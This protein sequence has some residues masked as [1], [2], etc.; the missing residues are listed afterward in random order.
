MIDRRASLSRRTGGSRRAGALALICSGA[1]SALLAPILAKAQSRSDDGPPQSISDSGL[2]PGAPG[3]L[4]TDLRRDPF[5]IDSF[6]SDPARTPYDSS[7]RGSEDAVDREDD[8][9]PAD[10]ADDA[11]IEADSAPE[12]DAEPVFDLFEGPDGRPAKPVNLA[13][14]PAAPPAA[15]GGAEELSATAMPR[16][17]GEGSGDRDADSFGERGGGERGRGERGR[18]ERGRGQGPDGQER[19]GQGENRDPLALA[20]NGGLPQRDLAIPSAAARVPIVET[21][22][23]RQNLALTALRGA[24]PIAEDDPFAPIGI[25]IGSAVMYSTV[26]QNVGVSSNLSTSADGESGVFSQTILS[27]RLLTDWSRHQFELNGLAAYRRNFAG[28]LESDPRVSLDGRFRLDI[29]RLTTATFRGAVDYGQ[30]DPIDLDDGASLSDR[31]QILTY[32]AG[33]GIERRFGRVIAALDASLVREDR[34][35][36]EET[37]N[38]V[39][40]DDSFTTYAASLRGGYEVSPALSP[41]VEGS[42]GLRRFD[43]ETDLSGRERNSTIPSLRT[44]VEFDL[45]EKFLGEVAVGYAFDIPDAQELETVGSPTIDARIAWSPHRGTDVVL[46]A[47]TVFDPD[48]DGSGTSTLYESALAL[49]HRLTHRTDVTGTVSLAY[50]DAEIE[51]EVE[52]SYAAEAGFT[53]WLNRGLA[54]TGLARHEALKTKISGSDYTAETVKVGIKLQR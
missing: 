48:P 5:S 21:V 24:I 36:P 45:G 6:S 22:T 37:A 4:P 38:L 9:D 25:R 26:E 10:V 1:L 27:Q 3:D 23:G 11:S 17:D 14:P 44:G 42:V 28:E 54:F 47:G 35:E 51:T 8:F 15:P 7:S 41:F 18:G 39:L 53:Y 46:T 16:R 43:D 19:S 34:S 31:P 33:A 12:A 30:E 32:S 29:D 13:E 40:L 52:T 20:R 49:R 50:R 2:R